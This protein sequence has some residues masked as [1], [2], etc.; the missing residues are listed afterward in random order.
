VPRKPNKTVCGIPVEASGPI[1][2]GINRVSTTPF[3][4]YTGSYY[5]MSKPAA[6]RLMLARFGTEKLPRLNTSVQLC[7]DQTLD[8]VSGSFQISRNTTG[9][10]RGP[11]RRRR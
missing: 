2:T 1:Y 11:R 5:P 9:E 8:N 3:E 4:G 7:A 10:L 6:K